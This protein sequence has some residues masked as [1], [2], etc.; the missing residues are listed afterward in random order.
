MLNVRGK[1]RKA[2]G[3]AKNCLVFIKVGVNILLTTYC[4]DASISCCQCPN[5]LFSSDWRR[6]RNDTEGKSD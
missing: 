1:T 6:G 3:H 5:Y 4:F 2:S